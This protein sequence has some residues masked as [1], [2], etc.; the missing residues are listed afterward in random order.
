VVKAAFAHP[1][2]SYRLVVV[3]G[4]VLLILGL[5]MVISASS[6]KAAAETDD[7]YYFGKRQI[8]FA[9]VGLLGA[10]ALS[11]VP[12]RLLQALAW[13]LMGLAFVLL[14][15]T[16]SPLGVNVAGNTNWLRFG[17]V[18][19]QFQPSEF[20]KLAIIVFA[21]CNLYRRRRYLRD[22]R[23]W[24]VV[25]GLSFA[26]V[27]WVLV[28]QGDMGTAVVMAG[29]IIV[30]LIGAGAPWRLLLGV[31]AVSV[32]GAVALIVAQP[33]RMERFWSFLNQ[34]QDTLG[35]NYQA[36]RGIYALASGGWFGR[37]LG[38]SRQKWGLL[39]EAHTDY[40]FAII[41]E[42]LGLMGTLAVILL[43]VALAYAGLRIARRSS[44]MSNRLI[45]IGVVAWFTVQA[46]INIAVATQTIPVMGVTL[47]MISYGGSSLMA[48][49]F[50]VGLLAGAARHE[51]ETE[52]LLASRKR[53]QRVTSAVRTS[54]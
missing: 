27:V 36:E 52:Q 43:F 18:W 6:V 11:R 19:T 24:F 30:I 4:A 15:L 12:E 32:V 10:F 8:G 7:P 23:Q 48:N 3:V 37:G 22:L 45:A 40:I 31:L 53:R 2:F 21:A 50:A 46:F 26:M 5:L 39:S 25:V 44:T 16:K 35:L 41:G 34:G 49:L 9:V 14:V 20:A 33:Y 51:A 13:P 42:E 1:L 29:M 17:P 54:A 28:G 47:P 38:S